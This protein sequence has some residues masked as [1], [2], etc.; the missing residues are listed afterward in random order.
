M[1]ERLRLQRRSDQ[2]RPQKKGSTMT[3]GRHLLGRNL[4]HDPA[5]FDYEHP[6][7]RATQLV[8]TTHTLACP[9]L[10]Q[11]NIGS[12]E[13]N[14]AAEFISCGKA[15]NNRRAYW[16][17]STGHSSTHYLTEVQAVELYSVATRLDNDN[18]P[19]VYPPDDTGTSGVGIAK[20]MQAAGALRQYNWTF[21]WDAF[22]ATLQHQPIMLG[23]NWY[24]SMFSHD[25]AG[26]VIPPGADD[27]VAGGHAILAFAWR[28]S[29]SKTGTKHTRTGCTNHWVNDDGTPWGVRIGEHDGCF[30][31]DDDLLRHLLINE[32]GD[33]LVPVLM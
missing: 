14:T 26:F 22:L 32:Q 12:C 28:T 30:W 27:S 16:K 24:D 4:E 6:I 20:A 25:D 18:I 11:G 17:A 33:S 19:G 21:T 29:T 7:R 2:G 31:F 23:L 5:S 13:P 3:L 9:H 10:N 15:I 8:S 1:P